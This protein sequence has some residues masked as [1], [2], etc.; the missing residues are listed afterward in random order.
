[1]VP[2]VPSLLS[3][4]DASVHGADLQTR[5]RLSIGWSR[6]V[7]VVVVVFHARFLK[8]SLW[9]VAAVLLC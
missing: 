1:M 8:S 5:S 3:L 6:V 7:V 4:P 2:L 9:F